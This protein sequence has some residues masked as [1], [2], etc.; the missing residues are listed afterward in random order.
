MIVKITYDIIVC[1]AV[2]TAG[3]TAE[4]F[5]NMKMKT[6]ADPLAGSGW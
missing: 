1:N 4:D 6:I 2:G 3:Q 5:E